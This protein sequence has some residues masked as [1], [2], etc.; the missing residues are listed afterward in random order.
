MLSSVRCGL[1][2]RRSSVLRNSR[3]YIIKRFQHTDVPLN[4]EVDQDLLLVRQKQMNDSIST[5]LKSLREVSVDDLNDL[6]KVLDNPLTA[7]EKQLDEELTSFLNEF[8]SSS[9]LGSSQPSLSTDNKETVSIRG[10]LEQFPFLE[11]SAND[12]PYTPQ[13]LFLRQLKHAKQSARLG[14]DVTKVYNPNTHL[15]KPL[16]I[17]QVSITKLM[18]A[19]VHLGQSTSLWRS[20]TQPFIYGEYKGIHIIDMNKTLSYLKRASAVIEGIVERGG[21]VL[22]LG[23]REGQKRP[24]EEAAKRVNG[25]YVSTRWIP[26]TLTNPTE[27]SGVWEKLEVDMSEKS[28]GRLLT[29][30]ENASIVKPDLLVVLNP[31]EN[32]NALNEAMK[33][34]VPTIGIIDTDSEPSFVTYPIPGNDDSYRSISLILGVL[35]KAGERGLKTRLNKLNSDKR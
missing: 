1:V 35:A 9:S 20:S 19:G 17:D 29:A 32:R 14:A 22:F 11:P 5:R 2:M 3:G 18:E 7:K 27:I 21:I 4:A 15:T 28:T 24:L 30:D 31:T 26:G 10:Q 16:S 34:R 33:T 13:E 8:S 25:Y 23:T 12:K 6:Q